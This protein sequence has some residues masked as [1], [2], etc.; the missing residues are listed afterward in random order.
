MNARILLELVAI[1]YVNLGVQF[2][3]TG[4]MTARFASDTGAARLVASLIANGV[5]TD[6]IEPVIEIM[7]TEI[8][9]TYMA[10]YVEFVVIEGR[11]EKISS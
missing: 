5:I 2:G 7:M 10:P 6:L 11:C 4:E 1:T 8:I 3:W 9:T